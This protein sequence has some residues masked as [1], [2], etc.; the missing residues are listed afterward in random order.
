MACYQYALINSLDHEMLTR[1]DTDTLTELQRDSY[2]ILEINRMENEFLLNHE[3]LY[4][5]K[6]REVLPQNVVATMEHVLKFRRNFT[7]FV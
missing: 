1:G 6:H 5:A 3:E 2:Y 7:N 4:V